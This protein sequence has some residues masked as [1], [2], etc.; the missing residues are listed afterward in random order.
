MGKRKLGIESKEEEKQFDQLRFTRRCKGLFKKAQE[1][2]VLCGSDIAVIVISNGTGKATTFGSSYPN[3]VINRYR[4]HNTTNGHSELQNSIL[5]RSGEQMIFM[6][7][8]NHQENMIQG[9]G[10]SVAYHFQ[11]PNS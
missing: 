4:S 7:D 1:L 11:K 3:S 6:N 2:N 8:G 5:A 10:Y 9:Q